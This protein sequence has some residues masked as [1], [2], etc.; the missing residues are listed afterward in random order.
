MVKT[1]EVEVHHVPDSV[2]NIMMG[3]D[4]I[5]HVLE[6]IFM[7]LVGPSLLGILDQN[8]IL[9]HVKTTHVV[10]LNTVQNG[11]KGD[12]IHLRGIH[13]VLTINHSIP[14]SSPEFVTVMHHP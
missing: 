3:I 2:R 4:Y 6:R 10:T 12:P 7:N 9:Q 1:P 13:S 11:K 8:I 14:Q 5:Q